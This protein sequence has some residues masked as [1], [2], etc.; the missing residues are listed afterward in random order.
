MKKRPTIAICYDFDGTLSPKSMQEYGYIQELKITPKNFWAEAKK[1]AKEQ[2]ADE[3]L[4]YMHLMLEKAT[5]Q[6]GVQVT[7]KAFKN[8]GKNLKL[9]KGVKSWFKR[10]NQYA[11]THGIK[12]EHYIIS[13][14]IKE[15]ILGSEISK[16]FKY[17]YASSFIYDQYGRAIWPAHALNY[18]TKTQC[19]FRIN[20]GL[21]DPSDNT[22]INSYLPEAE[23]PIPFSRMVYIGDGDTD[24]PCMKLVKEQ[25][26]YSIAVY[27]PGSQKKKPQARGLLK[28]HRVNFVT[29]ADYRN[30]SPLDKQ[31]KLVLKKM[32][33]TYNLAVSK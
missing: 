31:I 1:L 26:G 2:K 15:M 3:I 29:P 19:L 30:G 25:G 16:E 33:A 24:I 12:C 17:I 11:R 5:R 14:G 27:K 18:T 6:N 32:L 8:F 23:R 4:T 7:S 13:S 9:F 22:K 20:K 28:V 21:L 10:I